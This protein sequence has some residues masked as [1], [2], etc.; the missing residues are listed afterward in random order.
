[1]EKNEQIQLLLDETSKKSSLDYFSYTEYKIPFLRKNLKELNLII[2][3]MRNEGLIENIGPTSRVFKITPFGQE[4]LDSGGWIA[5]LKRRNQLH[6]FE[7]D[8]KSIEFQKLKSEIKILKWQ[9]KT[10][11]PL[12][13][14]AL[15]GGICG[16][17]SLAIQVFD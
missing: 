13:I 14:F 1:M 12:F 3:I 15:I 9:E 16:I 4:V 7:N 6:N 17:V 5:F 8:K 2:D 11:W 10:F